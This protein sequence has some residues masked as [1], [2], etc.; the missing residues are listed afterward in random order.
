MDARDGKGETPLHKAARLIGT[1]AVATALL[2]VGADANARDERD[3]RTP[4][5]LAAIIAMNP[6]VVAALVAGGANVNTRDESGWAALHLVA[7][8]GAP[9]GMTEMI[10]GTIA[11]LGAAGADMD[12]RITQGWTALHL[13]ALFSKTPAVITALIEAGADAGARNSAGQTPWDV[14]QGNATLRETD[15]WWQLNDARF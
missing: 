7:T 11:A 12:A 5:H 4:L 15:A 9:P 13:A 6:E 8:T 14:A 1:P 3:G 10:T 2:E